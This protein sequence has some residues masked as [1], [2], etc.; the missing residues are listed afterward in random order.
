MRQRRSDCRDFIAPPLCLLTEYAYNILLALLSIDWTDT[1]TLSSI[2][3]QSANRQRAILSPEAE[4][5]L[6]TAGLPAIVVAHHFCCFRTAVCGGYLLAQHVSFASHR[7]TSELGDR[8]RLGPRLARP[9]RL[10]P[11]SHLQAIGIARHNKKAHLEDT[12]VCLMELGST[13]S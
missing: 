11:D 1:V 10:L 7:S 2:R 5:N 9:C 8:R 12:P 6:E 4:E 13:N 3:A